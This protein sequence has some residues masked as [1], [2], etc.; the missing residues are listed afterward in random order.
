MQNTQDPWSPWRSWDAT[1]ATSTPPNIIG[2]IIQAD[3]VIRVDR[4]GVASHPSFLS[5]AVFEVVTG[6]C[7]LLSPPIPAIT[8]H[9]V[10][11]R[12]RIW[13][14]PDDIDAARRDVEGDISKEELLRLL[15]DAVDE[16]ELEAV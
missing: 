16:T 4:I 1:T 3:L 14:G 6:E 13:N 12:F 11:G 15:R 5:G 8:S 2:A 7:F 10:A 9:I